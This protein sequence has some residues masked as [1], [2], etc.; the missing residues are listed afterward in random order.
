MNRYARL[1][2]LLLRAV[3]LAE[4]C[5]VIGIFIPWSVMA[6]SHQWLGMGAFPNQPVVA[7][8]ARTLSGLYAIHGIFV[9]IAAGE[10]RRYSALIWAIIL[11]GIPFGLLATAAG[12]LAGFPLWWSAAEGPSL[13]LLCVALAWMHAKSGQ[14]DASSAIDR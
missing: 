2:R 14:V 13:V 7:Y 9:W 11:T 4:M 1:V 8:L 5:A 12:I 10:P 3:A 6:A